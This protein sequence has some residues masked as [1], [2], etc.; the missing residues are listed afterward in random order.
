MLES[1]YFWKNKGGNMSGVKLLLILAVFLL[2]LCAGGA[3]G[4]YYFIKLPA[5]K[6]QEEALARQRQAA[7]KLQNDISAVNAFYAKSLEGAALKQ[8][9]RLLAEIRSS[10]ESLSI[11]AIKRES[12]KCD[13]K[14][15]TFGYDY[16]PGELLILPQKTFWGKSYKASVTVSKKKDKSNKKS[17]F[18]Y[19]GIESRLNGN[20]L[21]LLYKSKKKLDLYPCDKVISYVLTYDSFVKN[22]RRD[23]KGKGT[24]EIVIKGM[25]KSSV[26]DL[27]SQLTGKV[28]AYGLMAGT[29]ELELNGKSKRVDDSTL[30]L[31]V[32]LYQQAYNDAFLIKRIES[33]NKGIKVS[34]GLVC[35][36]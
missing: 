2:L 17:D 3:G 6:A 34:G 36:V 24:G 21:Q 18:E 16:Q 27:E 12:F 25:P 15:C 20:T 7:E 30:N 9:I 28:K 23:S 35:K 5:Q 1:L 31:Q 19:K 4:W 14:N 26:S 11:L 33:T 29:W 10:R 13:A 32:M 8:G 22:S